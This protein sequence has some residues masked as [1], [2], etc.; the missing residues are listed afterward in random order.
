MYV[1]VDFGTLRVKGESVLNISM[2]CGRIADAEQNVLESE[3]MRCQKMTLRP[4]LVH[5]TTSVGA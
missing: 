5:T 4:A 3:Q 1:T 2:I